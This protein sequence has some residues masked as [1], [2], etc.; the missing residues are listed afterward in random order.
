[1]T[2]GCL[3]GISFLVTSEQVKT[4][5]RLQYNRSAR[6]SVHQRHAASGLAEFTGYDPAT[7]TF[8]VRLDRTLGIYDVMEEAGKFE[9]Y[10]KDGRTVPLVIGNTIYGEYRWLVQSCA[11]KAKYH[12]GQGDIIAADLTLSLLEYIRS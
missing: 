6:I 4:L 10:M 2:V 9:T 11:L 3:G 5:D 12:D 7:V 1:M 8:D